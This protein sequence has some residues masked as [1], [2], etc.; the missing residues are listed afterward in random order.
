MILGYLDKNEKNIDT[1]VQ[2]RQIIDYAAN[3][4]SPVDLFLT[5]SD[6]KELIKQINSGAHTVIVANALALGTTLAAIKTNIETFCAAQITIISVKENA[7]FSFEDFPALLKGME[8]ALNIRNSLSSLLTSKALSQ[9]KAAGYTLGRKTPNK[10][11]IFDGREEEIKQKLSQ[12]ITK[13]K[14]AKDLGVSEGYLYA[15]LKIHPELKPSPKEK[16]YA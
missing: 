4:A 5:A 11:H 6:I 10:K 7:V 16:Q 15:F 14:L 13:A 2:H 9:K 8:L 12:G 1:A 3:C